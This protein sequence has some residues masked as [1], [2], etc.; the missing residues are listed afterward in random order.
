MKKDYEN[1]EALMPEE[2]ITLAA[3]S[4][5]DDVSVNSADDFVDPEKIAVEDVTGRTEN[6]STFI[7]GTGKRRDVFYADNVRFRDSRTG[8]FTDVSAAE[9]CEDDDGIHLSADRGR[10]RTRFNREKDS[11]EL[12]CVEKDNHKISFFAKKDARTRGKSHAAEVS[13]C[14]NKVIFRNVQ[15]NADLEYSV[16]GG[17]VKEDIVI[18][19]PAADYRY[20]FIVKTENL[21][22]QF[23]ENEKVI[24]FLSCENNEEVF[25]IPAPFMSDAGG[26]V[27]SDVVYEVK[28]DRNGDMLLSVIADS[29]WINAEE[30]AF[31]VTID[32]QV[33]VSG[34]SQINTYSW[35]NGTVSTGSTHTVGTLGKGDGACNNKRMYIRVKPLNIPGTPNIEKAELVIYQKS[36]AI[37]SEKVPKFG[38]YR[39]TDGIVTGKC[40]PLSEALLSDYAVMQDNAD[41]ESGEP[42]KY[43]FDVTELI[44]RKSGLS[45]GFRIFAVK[46]LD[47]KSEDYNTMVLYGN[48]SA[49]APTIEITY[50]SPYSNETTSPMSHS[51]GYF[52]TGSVDL[53]RGNL[54]FNCP[55]FS[56]RG[57]RMPVSVNFA[58]NSAIAEYLY[59]ANEDIGINTADFSNM[60]VGTGWMMNY[61]QSVISA[62]FVVEGETKQGYIYTDDCA[63]EHFLTEGTEEEHLRVD[64]DG[65]EYCLFADAYGGSVTYDPLKKELYKYG[66]VYSFDDAGRLVKISEEA[67]E[68]L[69]SPASINIT[70]TS[71]RITS[72]TDGVGREF[73]FGYNTSGQLISITAPDVSAVRFEYSDANRLERI[74]RPGGEN[75]VIAYNPI[76]PKQVILNDGSSN[77]YQVDYTFSSK[78][79]TSITDFNLNKTR[80]SYSDAS[81]STVVTTIEAADEDEEEKTVVTTY[82]MDTDGNIIS[83]YAYLEDLGNTQVSGSSSEI[84]PMQTVSWELRQAV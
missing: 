37:N 44:D 34:Y 65:N 81:R 38:I 80:F 42:V 50:T 76:Y 27:S 11:N 79:C 14:R 4:S 39:V 9:I 29:E 64:E 56:W 17:K 51:I 74:V 53:K 31:P 32:P 57:N 83:Q 2:D 69:K 48:G 73:S 60:I 58:Y 36:A 30:R 66:S 70:Y 68:T 7:L 71:D 54:K 25:S 41:S 35:F 82:N 46:M 24:K 16:S 8:E 77:T 12:F 78:Q 28:E 10:F 43:T 3:G 1:F 15:D 55:I 22:P 18:T 23:I 75:T 13:D 52:G 47:E 49:Y 59:T 6:K 20:S 5:A 67:T 21:I 84:T 33:I 19:A 61:M 63:A 40:T 62:G 26:E 72:V 45:N